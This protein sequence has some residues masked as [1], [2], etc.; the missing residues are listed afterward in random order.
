MAVTPTGILVDAPELGATADLLGGQQVEDHQDGIHEEVSH[1]PKTTAS[2]RHLGRGC[3][4]ER[5]EEAEAP[6]RLSG[7]SGLDPE[8][9][10]LL[11][12]P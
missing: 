12:A 9:P 5:S 1:A 3:Q 10:Y 4:Q 7:L 2:I 11:D 8:A 6:M